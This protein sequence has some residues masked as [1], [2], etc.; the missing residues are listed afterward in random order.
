[1]RAGVDVDGHGLKALEGGAAFD[2]LGR[3]LQDLLVGR[4]HDRVPRLERF[5]E[6]GPTPPGLSR[7]SAR[8][9]TTRVTMRWSTAPPK[10]TSAM[11][12]SK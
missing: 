11:P 12:G 10:T 3:A 9:T 6:N 4:P 2:A 8:F 5:E 7:S 1:M